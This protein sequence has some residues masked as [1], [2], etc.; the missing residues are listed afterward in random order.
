[1][2]YEIGDIVRVKSNES[3]KQLETDDCIES[4]FDVLVTEFT[5]REYEI[6][7]KYLDFYTI[8]TEDGEEYFITESFIEEKVR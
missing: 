5:Q 3:F 8:H 2:S 1:M 4:T 6:I 7:D